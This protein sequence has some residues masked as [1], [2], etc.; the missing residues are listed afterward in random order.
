MHVLNAPLVHELLPGDD[1]GDEGQQVD[2]E[3][4]GDVALEIDLH[5][6]AADHGED[7]EDRRAA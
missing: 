6:S 4:P 7:R 1:H 2:D 3:K 5:E